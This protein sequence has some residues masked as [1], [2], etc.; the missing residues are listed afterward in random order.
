VTDILARQCRVFTS[1]LQKNAQNM[2]K[3]FDRSQKLYQIAWQSS[4][5]G[6]WLAVQ[7]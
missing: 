2:Q 3:Y 4:K 1:P 7:E 6:V 5:G